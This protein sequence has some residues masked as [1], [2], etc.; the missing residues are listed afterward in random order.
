MRPEFRVRNRSAGRFGG[1]RRYGQRQAGYVMK[2]LSYA[3]NILLERPAVDAFHAAPAHLAPLVRVSDQVL[4]NR[5]ESRDVSRR[6]NSAIYAIR[7]QVR[8]ATDLIRH[9]DGP[10]GI[11]HLI[12]DQGERLVHG[13]KH[14]QIAQIVKAGELR[15]VL[16]PK[17]A[18]VRLAG[19]PDLR[20]AR[21]PLAPIAHNKQIRPPTVGPRLHAQVGVDQVDATLAICELGGVENHGTAG[22]EQARAA[23][24]QL[25]DEVRKNPADFQAAFNLAGNYLQMQ[26]TDRANQ[27]LDGVLNSP[28]ADAMALRGLVT[29]YSSFGNGAG[30]QR[31]ADKLEALVRANPENF[32][33]AMGLA[34][35][36]RHLQKF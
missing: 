8:L 4:Q 28:Q 34:E 27:V 7:N 24:L 5:T 17:K 19:C 36:Y 22:L 16:K 9:H 30:L 15:L 20:L 10:A 32:Q 14:K 23:F 26:Q 29:A 25:E 13:R 12:H 18:R 33:A 1:R 2:R 31:A 35:A 21:C 11:H 3:P 6:K